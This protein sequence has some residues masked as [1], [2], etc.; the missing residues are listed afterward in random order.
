M[1]IIFFISTALS[2][3]QSKA[4]RLNLVLWQHLKVCDVSLDAGI[5][6]ITS[7]DEPP[8]LKCV[9]MSFYAS[10]YGLGVGIFILPLPDRM[11]AVI[12]SNV[13]WYNTSLYYVR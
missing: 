11:A 6:S 4:T 13:K 7:R 12:R 9:N 3:K 5:T 10:Q 2:S 1:M 8:C